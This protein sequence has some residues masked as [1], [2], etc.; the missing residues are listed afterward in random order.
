MFC[1]GILYSFFPQIEFYFF[2]FPIGSDL[3][4]LK[5]ANGLKLLF[6]KK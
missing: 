2:F 1:A 4:D 6:L 5:I 3:W